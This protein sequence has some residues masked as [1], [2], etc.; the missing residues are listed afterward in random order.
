[1][2][3]VLAYIFL[4]PSLII[5]ILGSSEYTLNKVKPL[6]E[7]LQNRNGDT[8]RLCNLKDYKQQ[9]PLPENSKTPPSKPKVHLSLIGDS[10]SWKI[11]RSDYQSGTFTHSTWRRPIPPTDRNAEKNILIFETTER[12]CR[13]R[14]GDISHFAESKRKR[15]DTTT[16]DKLKKVFSFNAEDNLQSILF[17]DPIS[18]FMREQKAAINQQWFGRI[19]ENVYISSNKKHLYIKE[20]IDTTEITSSFRYLSDEEVNTMVSNLN[21]LFEMARKEGYD[22]V[23]LSIPPNKVSVMDQDFMGLQ[24]NQLIVRVEKHP[25]LKMPVIPVL[26]WITAED[27]YISDTHWNRKGIEKWIKLVN[28]IIESPAGPSATPAL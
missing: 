7:Y 26:S 16:M 17:F 27:Y 25:S 15:E 5:L 28:Q 22:E 21:S 1:M 9:V 2:K 11:S 12:F 4:I 10:F 6:L 18:L 23:Y 3:K 8:Y 13:E 20:T 19:D 24:Y 14:F